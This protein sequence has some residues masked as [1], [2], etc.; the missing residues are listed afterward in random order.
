MKKVVLAIAVVATVACFSF[1]SCSKKC[2]CKVSGVETEY[3]LDDLNDA[4]KAL[5][6]KEVDKCTDPIT[7]QNG[8]SIPKEAWDCTEK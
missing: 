3:K 2:T 6:Y 5:N 4:L 1:T 7:D 8:N